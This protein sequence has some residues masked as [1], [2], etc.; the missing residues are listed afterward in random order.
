MKNKYDEILQK[1]NE[2]QILINKLREWTFDNI[3]FNK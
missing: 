3:K 2:Q 1:I